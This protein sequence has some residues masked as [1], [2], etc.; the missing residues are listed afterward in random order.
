M[1]YRTAAAFLNHA[2]S[3]GWVPYPNLP[4]RDLE[5]INPM[6]MAA[7]YVSPQNAEQSAISSISTA[8]LKQGSLADAVASGAAN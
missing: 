4:V 8:M 2:E 3:H 5:F 7:K 1:L 6:G